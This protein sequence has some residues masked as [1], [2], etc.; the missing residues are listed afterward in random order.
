MGA[1]NRIG[2]GSGFPSSLPFSF[3]FFSSF[4]DNL[5]LNQPSFFFFSFV[6]CSSA[7]SAALTAPRLPPCPSD[8]VVRCN[9]AFSE[10]LVV[11]GEVEPAGENPSEPREPDVTAEAAEE[12]AGRERQTSLMSLSSKSRQIG[13][14]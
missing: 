13:M 8:G 11:D 14:M 7:R 1:N 9:P 4:F 6:G 3:T 5:Q 12:V 10:R 2:R